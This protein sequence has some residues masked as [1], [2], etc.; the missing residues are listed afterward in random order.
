MGDEHG[1]EIDEYSVNKIE[2]LKGPA[3]LMYGSDAMA[4]VINILTNVPAAEGTL[5]GNIIANYQSNNRFR[6]I[7]ANLSANSK[8]GFNWNLYGSYKAA[9]DY[10]N[11]YDGRVYN[12][13]FN[14]A[15]FGGYVG[16]N[17]NW[18]Y[19]H[20]I[21]GSYNQKTGIIEGDRDDEG[22]F[23]KPL[24]GGGEALPASEDFNSVSPQIPWQQI[25]HLKF[26]SDNSINIGTGRLTWQSVFNGIRGSNME[27][28]IFP[29]K[30][31]YSST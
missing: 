25:N 11:K 14:E 9:S 21:I 8:H 24:P 4:G 20:L 19:S 10:S 22:R 27:I 2:I 30:R 15:N 1:I 6:G 5:K 16:Y 28:L 3:S 18:G 12:S 17:G 13:K 31:I 7:G 26:V 29:M 23:I